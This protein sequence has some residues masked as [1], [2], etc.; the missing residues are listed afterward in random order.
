MKY[1]QKKGFITKEDE[2]SIDKSIL[3][4]I[5]ERYPDLFKIFSKSNKQ[6]SKKI[7]NS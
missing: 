4:D 2:E 7:I 5:K 3:D 6:I 1:Y